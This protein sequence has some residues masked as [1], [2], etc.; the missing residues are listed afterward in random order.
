MASPECDIVTRFPVVR[1]HSGAPATCVD[2][3]LPSQVLL[4]R[5]V[6]EALLHRDGAHEMRGCAAFMDVDVVSQECAVVARFPL[7]RRPSEAPGTRATN[8]IDETRQSPGHVSIRPPRC[9]PGSRLRCNADPEAQQGNQKTKLITQ[10]EALRILDAA[11]ASTSSDSRR[12][13]TSSLR[14]HASAIE[15]SSIIITKKN[16]SMPDLTDLHAIAKQGTKYHPS[17]PEF[18][19]LHAMDVLSSLHPDRDPDCAPE[20]SGLENGGTESSDKM[21]RGSLSSYLSWQAF[22]RSWAPTALRVSEWRT[23]GACDSTEDSSM[24]SPSNN[25]QPDSF[26]NDAAPSKLFGRLTC[27]ADCTSPTEDDATGQRVGLS[28]HSQRG[29]SSGRHAQDGTYV[30]KRV[31]GS[32][33][34]RKSCRILCGE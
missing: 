9:D 13:R 31:V 28:L 23:W 10:D 30:P 24:P 1:R 18:A 6:Q 29:A 19:D 27:D 8:Q 2:N 26:A 11:S 34:Y 5:A 33:A 17:M 25:S 21:N 7:V 12:V 16:R 32:P 15:A 3:T 20:G 4:E 22:A 14:T